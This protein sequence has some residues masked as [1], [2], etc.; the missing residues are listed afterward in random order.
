[1]LLFAHYRY[2]ACHGT[3]GSLR[4]FRC[5][6]RYMCSTSWLRSRW[7]IEEILLRLQGCCQ[8]WYEYT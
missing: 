1:M 5:R 6:Q 2:L 7:L 3:L 4:V 8:L